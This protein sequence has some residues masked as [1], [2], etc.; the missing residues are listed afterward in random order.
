MNKPLIA[1]AICALT[2]AVPAAADAGATMQYTGATQSS[3]SARPGDNPASADRGQDKFDPSRDTADSMK[4]Y[5]KLLKHSDCLV[6]AG[7]PADGIL[8]TKPNSRSERSKTALLRQR[9]KTCSAKGLGNVHSLVRGSLAEAMYMRQVRQIPAV[10]AARAQAFVNAEKAFQ[11][12]REQGDQVMA[13]VMSCMVAASPDKAHALLATVHGTT[14]EAT[15]MDVFFAAA[16][17]CGA[18][19]T[20]PKNLSR[21]F[22][23]AF[24]ADSAWRFART[25]AR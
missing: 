7:Q 25:A 10:D 12:E 9:V 1:L 24:V 17:K 22:I 16:Q 20:R 6:G 4:G 14:E 18:G 3:S 21:S 19:A 8:T 2:A 23:R 13:S 15:A 11:S 5:V